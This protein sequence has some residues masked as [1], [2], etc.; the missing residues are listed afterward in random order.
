MSLRLSL[1]LSKTI[2]LDVDFSAVTIETI[3][4]IPF[5]V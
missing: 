2:K 3:E 4:D 1:I 5:Q